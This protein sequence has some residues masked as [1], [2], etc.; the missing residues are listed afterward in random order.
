MRFILDFYSQGQ[1]EGLGRQQERGL[2]KEQE[3]NG[4]EQ[5]WE[6]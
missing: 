4:Q 2:W 6:K 1:Q 3:R 5:R